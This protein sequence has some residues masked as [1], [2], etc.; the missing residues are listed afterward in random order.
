[1]IVTDNNDRPKCALCA[2]YATG[3]CDA[4]DKKLNAICGLYTCHQHKRRT[5]GIDCCPKHIRTE[6]NRQ[7]ELAVTKQQSL[8]FD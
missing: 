2:N 4:Y 3:Q 7:G 6:R 5:F 8:F 1:M